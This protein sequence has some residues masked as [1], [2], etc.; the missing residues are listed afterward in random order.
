MRIIY[1]D[2]ENTD[3]L[4]LAISEAVK[5]IREGKIIV[6]P[7]DTI[8]GIGCDALN[9]DAVKKIFEI[10]KR[11]AGKPL[12]VIVK[13]ISKIKEIA[14][15]DKEKGK[16]AASIFP[17]PYTL[18]F[19]GPRNI[20]KMI[21]G[22]KNSIGIR[23]P[24]NLITKNISQHFKNPI[25]TT[26]VNLSGEEPLNDPFKIAEYFKNKNFAPDLILDCGKIKNARP[27]IVVDLT[28]KI[29]QIL[30]S[31]TRNLQEIMELLNKLKNN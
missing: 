12:S 10:K 11:D 9:E 28:R 27:S 30:R 26:S 1:V 16:V 21:T 7:T 20:P 22:E 19:P 18:V 15:V 29:P 6:Y 5:F 17:G 24:D 2:F 14:F 8:Y 25:V 13:D 4:D 3:K 31:G 23:I